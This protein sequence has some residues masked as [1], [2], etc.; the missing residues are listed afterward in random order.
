MSL[1]DGAYDFEY[2]P[3]QSTYYGSISY[4][5]ESSWDYTFSMQRTLSE[6]TSYTVDSNET[7][8]TQSSGFYTD[9]SSAGSPTMDD[10]CYSELPTS[11][12]QTL[13]VEP[14]DAT[15]L[16]A[17]TG[18]QYYPDHHDNTQQLPQELQ[19][20]PP[21]QAFEG[22]SES[23]ELAAKQATSDALHLI[24]ND[25]L[26]FGGL[27]VITSE[28]ITGC[29]QWRQ[30]LDQNAAY[31][32]AVQ[33]LLV[34]HLNQHFSDVGSNSASIHNILV[35]A[36]YQLLGRLE[37]ENIYQI[38]YY[39]I[40]AALMQRGKHSGNAAVSASTSAEL[41]ASPTLMQQAPGS[42]YFPAHGADDPRPPSSEKHSYKCNHPGCRNG[43]SRAADLERHCKIV[44]LDERERKKYHCDYKKCPRHES[45]FFRQDH[46]RDHLRD[47]HKEDLLRRSKR[48]DAEWWR[49]RSPYAI[50]NGWWRCNRCLMVRVNIATDGF[51][52]PSC[53]NTCE[54]E[55]QKLR[56]PPS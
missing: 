13:C 8:G 5:P 3:Q 35:E 32:E 50:K 7:A 23:I 56:M 42:S 19:L 44:H 16:V 37:G 11:W 6:T 28:A 46:F 2:Y 1:I 29:V 31:R 17:A 36:A 38:C 41:T 55:R 53:G 26:P 22:E 48:G 51:A 49:S 47:F 43:F 40:S 21:Q 4:L 45:P 52:C 34:S 24:K 14:Q 30:G 33:R 15:Q 18:S 27:S 54:P 20:S 12:Y 25:R 10:S 9:A 39:A